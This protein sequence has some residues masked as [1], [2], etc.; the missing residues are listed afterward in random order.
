MAILLVIVVD[1]KINYFYLHTDMLVALRD[2]QDSWR[3]F[4][5]PLSCTPQALSL[6][7][8]LSTFITLLG[9]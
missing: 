1:Y 8:M 7:G 4:F 5:L 3:P 2:H 6:A 9:V